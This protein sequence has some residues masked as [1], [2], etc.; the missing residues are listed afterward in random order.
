[1]KILGLSGK[2]RAGKSTVAKIMK[3]IALETFGVKV[4]V[5]SYGFPLKQMFARQFSVPVADLD[6]P[7]TKERFREPLIDY[8]NL[9]KEKDRYL[10][11]NLLAKEIQYGDNVVIDDM[12]TIEELELVVKW[13][14]L[15]YRV[16]ADQFIRAS[17]GAVYN[18]KIDLALGETELDFTAETWRC[19]KGGVIYNNKDLY[20]LRESLVKLV[21]ETYVPGV[22]A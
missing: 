16:E 22:L 21:R 6:D 14:G 5:L 8:A 20:T 19:L 15:P 18:P 17:R 7:I 3:E 10:F 1:M 2:R 13:G 11:V 9:L 4:K 12:R